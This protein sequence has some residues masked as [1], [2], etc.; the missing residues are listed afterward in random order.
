M[1][2]GDLLTT[3]Q[4]RQLIEN[5]IAQFAAEAYQHTLN[6][7]TA[8]S[9]GAEEQVKSADNSI[10]VLQKAIDVHK[11]ELMNIIAEEEKVKAAQ[12]EQ[13]RLAQEAALAEQSMLEEEMLNETTE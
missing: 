5:R 1:N 3:Q 13:D 2:F 8:E 10:A 6:K 9:I 7:Q 4:K 11:T 12:A